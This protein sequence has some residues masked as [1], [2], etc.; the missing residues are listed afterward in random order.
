[1]SVQFKRGP[2]SAWTALNPLL[3]AGQ[4]GYET[5]SGRFKI[6]D[7]VTLYNAL[8]YSSGPPGPQ[9][10]SPLPGDDGEVGPPTLLL[11]TGT[12]RREQLAPEG[13]NWQFLGSATGA[14][15][16]VGPIIWTGQY[17][18]LMMQ[19]VIAGYNGGT[20]VG[21]L[22]LGAASIST[23]ALT[24]SWAGS[25]GVT[26]PTTG[27]GAG[28]IPGVPLATTLSAIGRAGHALIDGA[29]GSVKTV[30]IVGNEGTPAVATV[31]VLYRATS[32]FSDLG[33]NLLL[34]R[35]QLTVY[36]TLV[37]AAASAQT[38]TA[39]TQLVVWG[40]NND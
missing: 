20:P 29:S 14:T 32:F 22:L 28:A 31:P 33:T 37:A 6:G 18:Q 5:D 35:A 24:N 36:D 21:R 10:Q 30:D 7:G 38:F 13:K 1:M 17:R 11:P 40:R 12:I 9:M 27:A 3:L 16:T 26:A 4:P 23:T 8:P 39:G 34:L 19:Y 15:V 2:F 25:E